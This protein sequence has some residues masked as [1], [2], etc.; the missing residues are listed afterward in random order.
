MANLSSVPAEIKQIILKHLDQQSLCQ[1]AL[2]DHDLY[3][4]ATTVLWRAVSLDLD[5]ISLKSYTGTLTLLK[6]HTR[7]LTLAVSED[8]DSQRLFRF[9]IDELRHRPLESLRFQGTCLNSAS[10][11]KLNSLVKGGDGVWS[12]SLKNLQLPFSVGISATN[13]S[14]ELLDNNV[15]I[16]LAGPKD[17]L[18]VHALGSYHD[19]LCMNGRGA[20]ACILRQLIEHVGRNAQLK[21]ISFQ[22]NRQSPTSLGNSVSSIY[23]SAAPKILTTTALCLSGLDFDDIHLSDFE[24]LDLTGIRDLKILDCCNLPQLFRCFMENDSALNIESF[25]CDMR[26]IDEPVWYEK[27]YNAQLFLMHFSSLTKLRINVSSPWELDLVQITAKH[28]QLRELEYCTGTKDLPLACVGAVL[29]ALPKLNHLAFCSSIPKEAVE[30]GRITKEFRKKIHQLSEHV[31]LCSNLDKMTMIMAPPT[32]KV[33]FS[34][35][36]SAGRK[37]SYEIV[38]NEIHEII[39]GIKQLN[40]GL[41]KLTGDSVNTKLQN[42]MRLLEFC[43]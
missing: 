9:L 8:P 17:D 16:C 13:S 28:S 32:K 31:S 15:E 26:L 5:I 22:G 33:K 10:Y 36:Q 29:Q 21:S 34:A 27:L 24:R 30:L 20:P 19:G 43:Y 14:I 42:A 35:K 11:R 39:P 23:N 41:R 37:D 38:A 7:H 4:H 18:V 6:T 3:F 2:V 40:F 12:S 25:E 1:V